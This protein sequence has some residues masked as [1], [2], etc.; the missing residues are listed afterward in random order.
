MK[1]YIL[2]V[3]IC[4][5]TSGFI[6]IASP[7]SHGLNKF[8]SFIASLVVTSVIIFPL[9]E[10][11]LS[12]TDLIFPETTYDCKNETDYSEI[13]AKSLAMSIESTIKKDHPDFKIN[14]ITVRLADT[15]TF[16]VTEIIVSIASVETDTRSVSLYLSDMYNCTVN[17]E[18]G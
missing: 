3:I 8:V 16:E 9:T 18:E 12:N 4:T 15:D 2:S 13:A 14:D 10:H 6:C 7:S 5:V 11:S 17:I 1:E